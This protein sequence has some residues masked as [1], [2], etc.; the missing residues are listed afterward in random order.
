MAHVAG[1]TAPRPNSLVRLLGSLLD[2]EATGRQIHAGASVTGVLLL[3]LAVSAVLG[4]IGVG[5]TVTVLQ[6]DPTLAA[7]QAAD[8]I[9]RFRGFVALVT[10][11]LLLLKWA[12][13][14]TLV[15]M[16]CTVVGSD[17]R[18]DR[19][20]AVVVCGSAVEVLH[21]AVGV[22]IMMARA[23]GAASVIELQPLTGLN[24]FWPDV[25]GPAGALLAAINPFDAWYVVAV[26]EGTR[27]V[28]GLRPMTAAFCVLPA[29]VFVTATQVALAALNSGQAALR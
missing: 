25:Q 18:Y 15:W 9:T 7:A 10:P 27:V 4:W 26:V 12:V 2:P 5:P 14:A 11:V 13:V 28:A 20:F 3:L 21:L 29:W 6:N 24:M 19:I 1:I 8:L 23:S 22:A 17:S 16:A